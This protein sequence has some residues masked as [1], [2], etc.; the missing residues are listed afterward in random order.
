MATPPFDHNNGE[1][2]PAEGT[3]PAPKRGKGPEP[4]PAQIT[5]AR[6]FLC[7]ALGNGPRLTRE[8]EREAKQQGHAKRTLD[9]ARTNLGVQKIPPDTFRGPWRMALKDDP[10]V[11]AYKQRK[12]TKTQQARQLQGN[13]RKKKGNGGRKRHNELL[14]PVP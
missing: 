3:P 6:E 12:E 11:A 4:T 8:I 13:G 5:K 14:V 9:R 7:E 1:S 10:A 2:E